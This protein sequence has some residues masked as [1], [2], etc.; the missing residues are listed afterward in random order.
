M[1]RFKLTNNGHCEKCNKPVK[2]VTSEDGDWFFGLTVEAKLNQVYQ[3]LEAANAKIKKLE[4]S[5]ERA[6]KYKETE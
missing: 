2:M 4:K 5:Q 6:T 1:E 3:Q